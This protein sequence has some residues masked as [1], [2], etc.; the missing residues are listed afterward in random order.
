[1][2]E[3]DAYDDLQSIYVYLGSRLVARRDFCDNQ[4]NDADGLPS[5]IEAQ[6]GLSTSSNDSDGDGT[7]DGDEDSDGDGATNIE[8]L[9]AGTDPGDNT[10]YPGPIAA[11]DASETA[12]DEA[13]TIDVLGNDT[14]S[15]QTGLT[16]SAVTQPSNGVVVNN[17]T[18]VT[19]TPNAGFTGDDTFSY[20]TTDGNGLSSIATVTV[21]V[22]F[23]TQATIADFI[24]YRHEGQTVV[25]WETSSEIHTAGF[26]LERL[27][28]KKGK[29]KQL[30]KHLLPGLLFSRNGG[31]YRFVDKKAKAEHTYSYRLREIEANGNEL[32]YGPYDITVLSQAPAGVEVSGG[33]H[34]FERVGRAL[35]ALELLRDK[36]K[37][38]AKKKDKASAKAR[39]SSEAKILVRETGM[40]KV[41]AAQIA[42]VLNMS[43]SKVRA[44]IRKRKLKLTKGGAQVAYQPNDTGMLFYAEA[45]DT[46]YTDENVYWLQKGRGKT[47]NSDYLQRQ[48]QTTA[49]DTFNQSKSIEVSFFPTP[50]LFYDPDADYWMWNALYPENQQ[51]IDLGIMRP[52]CV[53]ESE[54]QDVLESF[55]VISCGNY[56]L[57]SPG[58]AATG[59]ATLTVNLHGAFGNGHQL[60]VILNGENVGQINWDGITAQ[61][62]SLT[63]PASQLNAAGN[64]MQ[65]QSNGANNSAVYVN[66][67][68]LTYPRRYLAQNGALRFSTDK[69]A[70][71]IVHGFSNDQ[72]AV[73][74]IT[75]SRKPIRLGRVD[76]TANG[77]DYEARFVA[78]AGH[79]YLAIQDGAAGT[80]LALIADAPSTL[81]TPQHWVD[82]LIITSGDDLVE[83]AGAL[84]EY[85][86]SQGLRTLI[87]DLEDIYD[88]FNHGV[89]SADAIWSFLSYT[90]HN[91]KAAPRYV[92]LAGDGS[93]DYKDYRGKGESVVPTLLTPTPEGLFPSDNLYVDL[94]GNDWLP[95]M[96]IGRIPVVD[97]DELLAFADK[98]IAY[99]ASGG[100]WTNKM[101]LAADAPDSGGDFT[102]DS[103]ALLSLL[104]S[105][106]A[107]D[108]VHLEEMDFT[109]AREQFLGAFNEGR[110]FV[111]FIGHGSI[112]GI[113]NGFPGL[114]SSSPWS[115]DMPSLTN[116]DRLPVFTGMTC[117][118]GYFGFVNMES[119]GEA[120]V[121]KSD[122]GAIAVWAPSGLSLN[123]RSKL[124]DEGFY[125]ATFDDGEL[126]IGEAILK[127]QQHYAEDGK[128]RYILDIYNLLGDP[129]TIMK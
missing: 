100:D 128:N 38:H 108:T 69:A 5:C 57:P 120:L 122:G 19:Y 17:G 90:W 96:S 60:Q 64:T 123:H 42:A 76:I 46:Q 117:L 125:L 33:L 3:T 21:T 32:L 22:L 74:D 4:D 101:V 58:A 13:I 37:K 118:A 124:L 67:A 111:N 85:R 121:L 10:S 116:A 109:S 62:T 107:I 78:Q 87:V 102:A 45:I 28:P 1:M 9:N 27:D 50:E 80:P 68:S 7:L 93:I 61:S 70:S 129:A 119:L 75:D 25:Q 92:V 35:S 15:T 110:A 12:Q 95:E 72:L 86:S 97:G 114:L 11:D 89:K 20:T 115:N 112:S 43:E 55:Q 34:G 23:P 83:A 66:N 54:F 127:A 8:E 2:F 59:N 6:L 14:D 65:L 106:L 77:S 48:A 29:W 16:V 73:Y 104:P 88:E 18:D 51:W 79:H 84:S 81:K 52:D 126:V 41:N 105:Q 113:G 40:V 24:V 36:R 98:L 94:V 63:F 56:D 91:W 44:D 99:E 30:T 47:M 39:K 103:L 82:Y 26:Y 53:H 31:T 71:T 49:N